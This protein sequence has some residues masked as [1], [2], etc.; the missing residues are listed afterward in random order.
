MRG[1]EVSCFLA[2]PYNEQKHGAFGATNCHDVYKIRGIV[3]LNCK[4]LVVY[5]VSGIL[6]KVTFKAVLTW[7]VDSRLCCFP[8]PFLT[9]ARVKAVW[10]IPNT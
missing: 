7:A 4:L 6:R 5:I 9:A 10:L 3:E 2:E 1:E 8:N